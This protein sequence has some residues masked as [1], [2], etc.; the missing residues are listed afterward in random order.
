MGNY[1]PKQPAS[2]QGNVQNVAFIATAT[3]AALPT[4]FGTETFEIRLAATAACFYVISEFGNPVAATA[5][6]GSFLPANVVEYVIVTPG[7]TL[8]VIEAAAAAGT[9]SVTEMS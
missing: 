8:S 7:Q 9:L 4:K 2:R 6:N 5:A 1:F 3:A